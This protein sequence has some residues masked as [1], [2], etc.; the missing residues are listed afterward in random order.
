MYINSF[1]TSQHNQP[2]KIDNK[3]QSNA[4]QQATQSKQAMKQDVV[5]ISQY[6]QELFNIDFMQQEVS[7]PVKD[8][9]GYSQEF[10]SRIGSHPERPKK[11]KKE[12]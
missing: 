1:G 7:H 9:T 3:T 11:K 10:I 4:Q 8:E 6:A 2:S 12:K 5:S